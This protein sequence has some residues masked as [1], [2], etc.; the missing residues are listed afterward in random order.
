MTKYS[1]SRVYSGLCARGVT[2][3][4]S[5]SR[6]SSLV[7]SYIEQ[8][9]GFSST[10]PT[11]DVLDV[12]GGDNFDAFDVCVSCVTCSCLSSFPIITVNLS[13]GSSSVFTGNTCDT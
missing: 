3:V 8:R 7:L 11:F 6:K 2:R 1:C 10:M 12:S 4:L 5:I 9:S 13:F